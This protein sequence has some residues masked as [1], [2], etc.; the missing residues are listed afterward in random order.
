MAAEQANTKR[1]QA[2]ADALKDLGDRQRR[3]R[4]SML[5][6][7]G[8]IARI[9]AAQRAE[10]AR[11]AAQARALL[12][13]R[14]F[15]VP[16]LLQDAARSSARSLSQSVTAVPGKT[17]ANLQGFVALVDA[18]REATRGLT[19]RQII[20]HVVETSGLADFYKAEK[21][22]QE[23]LEN[24][25]ELVNAAEAFVTQEGFGK[26]AVALPEIGRAHV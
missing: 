6:I 26:D 11:L 15:V 19:L 1:K 7:K 16:E 17:G 21:E 2:N 3:S 18:M 10:E 24:L 12:H 23:R 13:G 22:G 4:K 8:Q 9:Q 20:E 5:S 14:D 25:A